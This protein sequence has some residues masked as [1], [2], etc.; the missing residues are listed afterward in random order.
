[1]AYLVE[2]TARAERDFVD[3]YEA[4][5]AGQSGAAQRWYNGLRDA[6]LGLEELPHRCPIVRKRGRVRQLLYGHRPHV[7]LVLYRALEKNN[8]VQVLHIRHGARRRFKSSE[9]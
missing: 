3:L 9:L 8:L 7:Y 5:A 6:I 4:L 1:M 2:M